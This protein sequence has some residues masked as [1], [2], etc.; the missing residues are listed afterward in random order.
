LF[1][2]TVAEGT[3][4]QGWVVVGSNGGHSRDPHWWANLQAHPEATV[5]IGAR[6]LDVAEREAIWP[7]LVAMFKPY[8]SY[9]REAGRAIPLVALERA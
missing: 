9:R 7:R 2:V 5:Q 3:D 8:E 1:Y 4:A 6:A